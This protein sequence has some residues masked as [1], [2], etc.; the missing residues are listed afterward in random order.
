MNK[1]IVIGVISDTHLP[2][3]GRRLPQP[4]AA[5]LKSAAVEPYLEHHA[6]ILLLNPGSPTDRRRELTFSFGLLT[7]GAGV[8]RAEIRRYK[9]QS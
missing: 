5:G 2:R 3:F 6:G 7:L 9:G 1:A 8:P 4:L